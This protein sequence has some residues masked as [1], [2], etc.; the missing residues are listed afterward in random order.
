MPAA[1]F[2][3]LVVETDVDRAIVGT[4]RTWMPTYLSHLEV[5]RDLRP[6]LL[7][8]P[9][10]ESFAN[11]LDNDEFL[12]HALPAIV[13]TT[14]QATDVATG[15]SFV[16]QT[17]NASFTVVVSAI[18]RGRTP[19]ETREVA[20]LF[21]GCVRRILVQQP[22]DSLDAVV[23]WDGGAVSPLED[24]TDEG[25][26]LAAAMNRFVVQADNVISGE[27]PVL[28]NDDNPYDP[29]DPDAPDVPYDPLAVVRQGGVSTTVTTRS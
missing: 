9:K 29:P 11:A 15:P 23:H 3:D 4:L 21:G 8:R 28:P 22:F 5:E 19:G 10:P 16:G 6:R 7:A 26:Y 12:D 2:G 20:A 17:Y 24:S 27:G 25:R 18:V 1:E 13:V 14:A